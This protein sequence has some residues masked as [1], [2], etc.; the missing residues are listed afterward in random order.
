MPLWEDPKLFVRKSHFIDSNDESGRPHALFRHPRMMNFPYVPVGANHC[1]FQ[2]GI[3]EID[4]FGPA[5]QKFFVLDGYG[6]S[7]DLFDRSDQLL[8]LDFLKVLL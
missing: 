3:H 1:F 5:N 6:P 7:N 2:A 4:F 8:I